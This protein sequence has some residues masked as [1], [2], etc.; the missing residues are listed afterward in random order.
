M[1]IIPLHNQVLIKQ[2]DETET[3][4]GNIIVPDA[5]K[6]KPLMGT[7]IASGPGIINLQ[8]T[9][10]PNTLKPGQKVTFPSFGGQRITVKGEEYLIYK[11]QD[12]LAILEDES[13]DI[14]Y[15]LSEELVKELVGPIK[16][17]V[18]IPTDE[19]NELIKLKEQTT[20]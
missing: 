17:T 11:E 16:T 20:I 1:K 8:G 4:Y 2:Q 14:P 9:L 3:M 15:K 18:T 13:S 10:I 6:E 7:V 12:I 5:G 19:Y